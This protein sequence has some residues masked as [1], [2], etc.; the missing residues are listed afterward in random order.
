MHAVIVSWST[1]PLLGNYRAI[2]T[3][4]EGGF[5]APIGADRRQEPAKTRSSASQLEANGGTWSS[6]AVARKCPRRPDQTKHN[7]PPFSTRHQCPG[8]TEAS[9]NA[10]GSTRPKGPLLQRQES[11]QAPLDP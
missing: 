6:V 11:M 1:V 4:R 10:V 5:L 2:V 3:E 8:V 9:K 7:S